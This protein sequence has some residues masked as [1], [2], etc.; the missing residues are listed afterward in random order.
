MSD[1][2]PVSNGERP[3]RTFTTLSWLLAGLTPLAGAGGAW[4]WIGASTSARA[5]ASGHMLGLDYSASYLVL[6]SVLLAP[7]IAVA[8]HVRYSGRRWI[9]ATAL[10]L[11]NFMA[12]A[13]LVFIAVWTWWSGHGCFT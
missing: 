12:A 6:G 4:L 8:W 5:C 11:P 2:S 10:A 3:E 1:V 7:P 13:V 9:D